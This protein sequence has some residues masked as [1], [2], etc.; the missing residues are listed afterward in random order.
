MT[1]YL[2]TV[3]RRIRAF[4]VALLLPTL[5]ILPTP[6]QAFDIWQVLDTI[7]TTPGVS[8]PSE[9][10]LPS[11][12]KAVIGV[13]QVCLDQPPSDTGII[14]CLNT[15]MDNPTLAE[16]MPVE[17][18]ELAIKIYLDIKSGDYIQLAIDAGKPLACL[19]APFIVGFDVCGAIEAILAVGGAVVSLVTAFIEGLTALA[20]WV[21][22]LLGGGPPSGGSTYN[23]PKVLLDY[24][25][26]TKDVA[27]LYRV[28]P[29]ISNWNAHISKLR[30]QALAT[31]QLDG[32][33]PISGLLA[34]P[35]GGT[36]DQALTAF[37]AAIGTRWDGW[38]FPGE[39]GVSG[40]QQLRDAR[41]LYI[42]NNIRNWVMS[43]Y[44]APDA[45][46]RQA[47][48]QNAT[49]QC[50]AA[51]T[52]GKSLENWK[53]E[54]GK[55]DPSRIPNNEPDRALFCQVVLSVAQSMDEAW[56][57]RQVALGGCT[58]LPSATDFDGLRCTTYKGL[59]ACQ[60]AAAAITSHSQAKGIAVNPNV[61][62]TKQSVAAGPAFV[63][64][65]KKHDPKNRCVL[66]ADGR[67]VNC[68]RDLSV[69]RACGRAVTDYSSDATI[70]G[71]VGTDQPIIDVQCKLQRD[72]E[73]AQLVSQVQAAIAQIEQRIANEA[74]QAINSFN[75]WQTNPQLKI[76][77][78]G[79]AGP[80]NAS[81]VQA[82][83]GVSI[84]VSP[85]D[86]LILLVALPTG[87][88]TAWIRKTVESTSFGFGAL[89]PEDVSDPDNDGQNRPAV[90]FVP[91]PPTPEQQKLM[92]A[93]ADAIEK[94]VKGLLT[95]PPAPGPGT[96]QANINARINPADFANRTDPIGRL[97]AR[98]DVNNLFSAGELEVLKGAQ[99]TRG[100]NGSFNYRALSPAHT[101]A[102]NKALQ[103][104]IQFGM[105]SFVMG[106]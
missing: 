77:V 51:D 57:A 79:S 29:D 98:Q 67:S 89:S 85:D 30:T 82:V 18:I 47:V 52:Q 36:V 90:R 87:V 40:Q 31:K 48:T 39:G 38:Y 45:A 1:P 71:L 53:F 5:V 43:H 78:G 14:T 72:N 37:I 56:N 103:L 4:V 97:L 75:T 13:V 83:S 65:L 81:Q 73:Y 17:K 28:A 49:Q 91:A 41:N 12:I 106:P 46:A 20:D 76:M 95:A 84:K 92:A 6:A 63:N 74:A 102:F 35:N 99:H 68:S 27:F 54:R 105:G 44:D 11:Q 80:T 26:T 59:G 32:V 93:I 69:T 15:A 34:P 42:K 25:M 19:A 58:L 64:V 10:P 24:F 21:A 86:P 96:V 88:D 50:L 55:L 61:L 9:L 66:A 101:A 7:A 62:C 70:A 22:D 3:V 16:Q 2:R 23:E 8:Y 33:T 94:K 100:A 104:S 60:K